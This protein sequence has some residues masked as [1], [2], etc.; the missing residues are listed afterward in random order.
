[1]ASSDHTYVGSLVP[2]AKHDLDVARYKQ[3]IK[4]KFGSL[5]AQKQLD[6]EM[7]TSVSKILQRNRSQSPQD[8]LGSRKSLVA[9]ASRVNSQTELFQEPSKLIS[10]RQS[11][12][13]SYTNDATPPISLRIP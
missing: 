3:M 8:D 12:G 5:A 6:D 10:L 7:V 2:Q 11:D 9:A 13:R 1:M 4:Q